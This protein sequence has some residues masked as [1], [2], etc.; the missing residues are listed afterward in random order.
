MHSACS[1]RWRRGTSS[2]VEIV[3]KAEQETENKWED[4]EARSH[5]HSPVR[6]KEWCDIAVWRTELYR[7]PLAVGAWLGVFLSCCFLN[8]APGHSKCLLD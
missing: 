8:L 5:R 2:K 3:L 4:E 7:D 6:E 1:E